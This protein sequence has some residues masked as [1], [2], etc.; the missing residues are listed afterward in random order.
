LKA[1]VTPGCVRPSVGI[2]HI[3]DIIA[4]IDQDF[5]MDLKILLHQT[6]SAKNYVVVL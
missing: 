5:K 4:Y 3:D 6:Y 2:K 1:G